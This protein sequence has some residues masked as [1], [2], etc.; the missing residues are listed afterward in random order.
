MLFV[1]TQDLINKGNFYL[2]SDH[3]LN[4]GYF[5]WSETKFYI[6]FFP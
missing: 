3:W 1:N 4:M 5:I 6:V 2:V